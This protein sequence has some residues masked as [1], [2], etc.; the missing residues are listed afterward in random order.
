MWSVELLRGPGVWWGPR[1]SG[2]WKEALGIKQLLYF[3][4]QTPG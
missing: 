1:D 3:V 2:Y 4:I